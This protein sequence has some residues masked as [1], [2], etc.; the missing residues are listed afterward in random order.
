M[1]HNNSDEIT[2]ALRA[3][4]DALEKENARLKDQLRE[5]ED[6][7]HHDVLT[8]LANR[9]FFIE[10]LKLRIMRCQRYGDRTALLF[11]DVDDL[12]HVNDHHGHQAGDL[13]LTK[14]AEILKRNI[15][16][17]DMV[18]RIGGDEFAILLDNMG[19]KIVERKVASLMALIEEAKIEFGQHRI[20]L[21]AAIGHCLIEPDDNVDDLMSRA[22]AA[23]YREKKKVG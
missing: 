10:G 15:R 5:M 19:S 7:A 8:G 4:C 14:L 22:D 2:N 17:S 13:V 11:L 23:M 12:K 21:S 18:A 1:G 20:S 16:A 6:R 3:R 9:R